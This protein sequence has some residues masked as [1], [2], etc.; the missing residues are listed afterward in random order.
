MGV[1]ERKLRGAGEVGVA[2]RKLQA[3]TISVAARLRS[4]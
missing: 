4:T 3:V 2:E 1:A